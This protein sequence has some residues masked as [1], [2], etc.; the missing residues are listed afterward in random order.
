MAQALQRETAALVARISAA[1][2]GDDRQNT[3]SRTRNSDA[4]ISHSAWLKK[5][6]QVSWT[7]LVLDGDR[8]EI[9][10]TGNAARPAGDGKSVL[11]VCDLW[12]HAYYL[13]REN[14]RHEF[15]RTF[16]EKLADWRFANL[17]LAL[18]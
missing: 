11:L 15:V 17:R 9:E 6:G 1:C 7:W 14:A 10:T 5:L 18:L 16:V 13:D 12:E 2:A 3:P 8:L 4:V